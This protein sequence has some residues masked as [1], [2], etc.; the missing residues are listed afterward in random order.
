VGIHGDGRVILCVAGRPASSPWLLSQAALTS[1]RWTHVAVSFDAVSRQGTIY[2]D[3]SAEASG[4]FPAHTPSVDVTPT[5]ARA[6][7]TD[8]YYLAV[9]LDRIRLEPVALSVQQVLEMVME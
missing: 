8:S 3:G 2:I 6:S 4:V 9:D 5:I 7:W 1:G